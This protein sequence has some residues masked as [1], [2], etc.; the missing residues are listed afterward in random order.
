MEL[1]VCSIYELQNKSSGFARLKNS[2]SRT[3]AGN[4]A[5][6]LKRCTCFWKAPLEMRAEKLDN[7]P[8]RAAR[9]GKRSGPA[10]RV[11]FLVMKRHRSRVGV[12][13]RRPSNYPPL[14]SFHGKKELRLVCMSLG[15]RSRLQLNIFLEELSNTVI[16]NVRREMW[17]PL[18]M[19]FTS[20][21]PP[22]PGKLL[23]DRSVMYWTEIGFPW[24]GGED[25]ITDKTALQCLEK[26]WE[27]LV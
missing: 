21:D 25:S 24:G 19:L 1:S 7:V 13:M 26:V 14:M 12:T 15:W 8:M 6:P 2:C 17:K 10:I 4:P 27:P 23:C 9:K 16:L 3:R 5:F 18:V 22:S 20:Y 11:I